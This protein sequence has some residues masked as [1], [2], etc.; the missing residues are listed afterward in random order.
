[1]SKKAWILCGGCLIAGLAVGYIMAMARYGS[2]V[3]NV[4]ATLQ[5][6]ETGQASD[7]AFQ[8]YQHESR[9]VAIYAF[10]EALDRLKTAEDF[11]PTPIYPKSMMALDGVMLHGRLA[12]LYLAAGQTNLCD[13]QVADALMC[14]QDVQACRAI[15]NQA[16]LMELIAKADSK[17]K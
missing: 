6:T 9:S 17:I 8:A 2:T 14:A 1:M 4:L 11:G 15:T 10:N 3:A 7:R 5:L 12:R 16:T 13:Q